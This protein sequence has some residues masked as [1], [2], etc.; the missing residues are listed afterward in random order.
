MSPR[1]PCAKAQD[2]LVKGEIDPHGLA[3]AIQY[4]IDRKQAQVAMQRAH[5]DLEQKVRE[6]TA[7]LQRPTRFFRC[8][9]PATRRSSGSRRKSRS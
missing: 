8:S 5:D 6:R 1:R 7:E 3:R 9:A 4:A 2:Y